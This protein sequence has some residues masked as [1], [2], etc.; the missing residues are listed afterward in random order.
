MVT[1][2]ARQ[3]L[4]TA[5]RTTLLGVAGILLMAVGLVLTLAGVAGNVVPTVLALLG[6]VLLV[7]G[8]ATGTLL[9]YDNARWSRN[10]SF[11]DEDEEPDE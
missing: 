9:V 2:R 10:Q 8:I 5:R 1:N 6:L 3:R 7:L 11:Y 4:R